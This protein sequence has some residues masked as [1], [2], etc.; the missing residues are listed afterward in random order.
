MPTVSV[1][2]IVRWNSMGVQ[3]LKGH[4]WHECRP[5]GDMTCLPCLRPRRMDELCRSS[6]V[7]RKPPAHPAG[8]KLENRSTLTE[9]FSP[10][11]PEEGSVGKA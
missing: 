10:I 7:F 1:R 2:D 5:K 4:G 9:F 6:M 11:A 3:R 8:H